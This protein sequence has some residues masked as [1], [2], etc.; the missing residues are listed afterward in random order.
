MSHITYRGMKKMAV[1]LQ[2][3]FCNACYSSDLF[4]YFFKINFSLKFVPDSL[5]VDVSRPVS[6]NGLAQWADIPVTR[7]NVDYMASLGHN[8]YLIIVRET[9][10]WCI[11]VTELPV[12]PLR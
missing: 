11:Y 4:I 5:I 8:E 7:T 10:T 1:I 3:T 6:D 2:T 9:S 12:L